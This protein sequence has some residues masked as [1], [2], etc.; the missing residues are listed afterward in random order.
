MA[1]PDVDAETLRALAKTLHT[2]ARDLEYVG[3]QLVHKSGS[4]HWTCAKAD[5][6]RGA[7]EARRTETHRVARDL[8]ELAHWV[9]AQAQAA[10]DAAAN[11]ST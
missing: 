1:P 9:L 10:E 4:A 6:Y 5:R 11:P 7:M 2:R 8:N 3:N